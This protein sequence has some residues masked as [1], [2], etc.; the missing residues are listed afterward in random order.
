MLHKS[1]NST[2]YFKN[3]RLPH[4]FLAILECYVAYKEGYATKL[5]FFSTL[6][7]ITS[8]YKYLHFILMILPIWLDITETI[9]MLPTWWKMK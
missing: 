7:W 4:C 2:N 6:I 1:V 3:S 8:P 9:P 5:D